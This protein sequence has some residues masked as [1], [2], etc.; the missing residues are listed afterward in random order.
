M[1]IMIK[2]KEWEVV[3]LYPKVYIKKYGSDSDAITVSSIRSI[4]FKTD[5][6]NPV[7]IRHELLHAFVNETCVNSSELTRDQMEELCCSL[8]GDHYYDIGQ[9]TDQILE[10]KL[11]KKI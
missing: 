9:L 5:A 10:I 2:G 7:V 11:R 1:K 6:F 3:F 4:F 8:L